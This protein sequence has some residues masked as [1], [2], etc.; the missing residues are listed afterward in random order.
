MQEWMGGFDDHP[1][2]RAFFFGGE[3]LYAVGNSLSLPPPPAP[4]QPSGAA[5]EKST[6]TN[7]SCSSTHT[8][9]AAPWSPLHDLPR[10]E[11]QRLVSAVTTDV[12][13]A[14]DSGGSSGHGG[15]KTVAD[16]AV[17]AADYARRLPP[18]YWRPAVALGLKLH[19]QQQASPQQQTM[20]STTTAAS[21]AAATDSN[22]ASGGSCVVSSGHTGDVHV[23]QEEVGEQVGLLLPTPLRG[24]K[25][26]VRF[27]R[28]CVQL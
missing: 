2:V 7:S 1:E 16:G 21:T 3:F 12:E 22:G 23:G 6:S 26:Q 27:R 13:A 20:H 5:M 4:L 15:R 11:E 19:Q 9:R 17:V 28:H 8:D 24:F 10:P 18:E 25:G 14:S